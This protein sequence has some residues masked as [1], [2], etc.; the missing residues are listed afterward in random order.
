M[1]RLFIIVLFFISFLFLGN[2]SASLSSSQL[3]AEIKIDNK[4]YG[5]I[6]TFNQIKHLKS[7]IDSLLYSLSPKNLVL[8]KNLKIIVSLF[9]NT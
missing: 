1:Y 5:N 2:S 4:S 9:K 8:D 6:G 3:V 7:H